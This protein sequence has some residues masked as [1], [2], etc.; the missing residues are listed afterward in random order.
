MFVRRRLTWLWLWLLRLVTYFSH[1][2]L[3][4]NITGGL[5]Q[6]FGGVLLAVVTFGG[7][8][9]AAVMFGG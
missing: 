2:R 1:Y 7:V 4:Y 8:S 5:S 6:V 3:H 9:L